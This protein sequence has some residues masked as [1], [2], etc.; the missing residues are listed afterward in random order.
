LRTS[1]KSVVNRGVESEVD[2]VEEKDEEEEEGIKVGG[3]DGVFPNPPRRGARFGGEA[4]GV[5]SSWRWKDLLDGRGWAEGLAE[6][7]LD[8]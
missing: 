7:L 5:K 2:E 1:K 6:P 3:G 8:L 4:G